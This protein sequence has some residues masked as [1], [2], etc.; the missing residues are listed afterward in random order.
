ML[1]T[2][3][4]ASRHSWVNPVKRIM[5]LVNLAFQNFLLTREEC[6]ATIEQI[7]KPCGEIEDIH[8]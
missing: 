3:R 4:T 2:T 1:I 7:L 5:S 6:N 8:N